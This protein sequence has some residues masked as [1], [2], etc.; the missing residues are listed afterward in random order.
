MCQPSSHGDS[1]GT[2]AH[3]DDSQIGP[4][5][6]ERGRRE[7][8]TRWRIAEGGEG[9]RKAT[10]AIHGHQ[11]LF[12][13]N[14]R[15][16]GLNDAAEFF[17]PGRNIQGVIAFGPEPVVLDVDKGIGGEAG[18]RLLRHRIKR[19]PEVPKRLLDGPGHGEFRIGLAST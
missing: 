18:H 4:M 11:E 12:T 15:Q 7:R 10:P 8:A 1:N 16:M 9:A 2:V 17:H 13:A 3:G 19:L 14:P 5:G 6:N